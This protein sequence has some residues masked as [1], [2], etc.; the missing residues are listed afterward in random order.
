MKKNIHITRNYLILLLNLTQQVN[1]ET[2]QPGFLPNS[3]FKSNHMGIVPTWPTRF[4]G[5]KNNL[6]DGKKYSLV[7]KKI[8]LIYFF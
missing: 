3:G 1:L 7:F 4:D 8:K 5:S 6:D 2:F